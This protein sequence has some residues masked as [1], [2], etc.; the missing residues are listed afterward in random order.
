MWLIVVIASSTRGF[1]MP[2]A[3]TPPVISPYAALLQDQDEKGSM[4]W[5]ALSAR[6]ATGH[7]PNGGCPDGGGT[8]LGPIPGLES[9]DVHLP[10]TFAAFSRLSLA[11]S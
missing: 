9:P 5:S 3:D 10:V 6:S 7:G 11:A 2:Q 4:S 8:P 1:A